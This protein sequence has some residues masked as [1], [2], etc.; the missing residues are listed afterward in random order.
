MS[1]TKLIGTASFES[2]NYPEVI[3]STKTGKSTT[4]QVWPKMI[5]KCYLLKDIF[6]KTNHRANIDIN[7]IQYIQNRSRKG[8][9]PAE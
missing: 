4:T 8:T 7:E 5:I 2:G 6:T 1:F 9:V 3:L